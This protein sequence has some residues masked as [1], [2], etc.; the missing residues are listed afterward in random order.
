MSRDYPRLS[1]LFLPY[2]RL[3]LPGIVRFATALGVFHS[4]ERCWR[5]AGKDDP[6]QAA[7]LPDEAALSDW[8][9]RMTYFLG[10]YYALCRPN[11]SSR[12]ASNR[13]TDSST[14]VRTSE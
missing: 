10:R 5:S 9:E 13:A 12:P 1:L 11:C 14:S 6:R 4:D 3:E 2:T 8:A 7:R